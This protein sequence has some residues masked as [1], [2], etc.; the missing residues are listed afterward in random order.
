MLTAQAAASCHRKR[1]RILQSWSA[2][3]AG[4]VYG[5][6][7][8][9]SDHH[10]GDPAGLQQGHAGGQGSCTFDA[11]DTAKG[12]LALFTGMISYHGIP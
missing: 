10:E 3:R 4:R 8:I 11:I 1:I 5:A 7:T 12:C 9:H 6:L 2:E